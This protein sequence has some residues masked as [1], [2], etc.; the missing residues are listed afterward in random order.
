[1]RTPAL[2]HRLVLAACI[3]VGTALAVVSAAFYIVLE[4][5]LDHDANDTLRSRSQAAFAT[6]TVSH[7]RL[8]IA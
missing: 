4:H 3:A 2:R 6:V 7:G 5:R 1:M 8:A